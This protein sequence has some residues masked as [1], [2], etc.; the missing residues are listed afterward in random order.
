MCLSKQNNIADSVARVTDTFKSGKTLPLAYRKKQITAV[1]ALFTENAEAIYDAVYKDLHKSR[2]ETF[3]AEIQININDCDKHLNSIDDWA[4]PR[5]HNTDVINLPA[6]TA[7]QPEP[8]GVALIV[9]CWNYPFALLAGPLIA[10]IAAGCTAVIKTASEEHAN[11]SMALWCELLPQYLDNEAYVIVSGG[12]DALEGLLEQ[13]Y[14]V[15]FATGSPGLGRMV[16]KAA[17]KH[18]TKTVLELGGKSPVYVHRDCNLTIG[19][20]R[21]MWGACAFNNG[22]TCVRPDHL[23]IDSTIADSFIANLKKE[24][25]AMFGEDAQKGN[26][27]NRMAKSKGH[28]ERVANILKTDAK[29]VVYGG[30]SDAADWYIAPTILDFGTDAEAFHNS[31][32]MQGEIFGPIIPILRVDTPE[33]AYKSILSREKPLSLYG[34]TNNK[35]IQTEMLKLPAGTTQFNDVVSHVLNPDAPFGGV[36]NS[37]MGAYHGQA[38]F[39]NFSH[40]KTVMVNWSANDL[41]AR[42]PPYSA[43][44]KR[45]LRLVFR[46]WP[47]TMINVL[48]NPAKVFIVGAALAAGAAYYMHFMKR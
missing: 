20:R 27:Y 7:T 33:V 6:V 2:T 1:R 5:Y 14:D 26:T 17:T 34:F 32:A 44:D 43:M 3:L 41:A 21:I 35:K 24:A 9:A 25:K 4:A 38:G 40:M 15:I 39:D 19:A 30:N 37:G 8:M 18:L 12:A 22:Q 47:D 36:G 13:R 45:L 29:Y 11:A 46:E 31:A 28:F 42:Y 10:C 23:F 16:H 48:N